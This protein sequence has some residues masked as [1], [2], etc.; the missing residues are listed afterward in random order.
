[1]KLAGSASGSPLRK[2]STRAMSAVFGQQVAERK[3]NKVIAALPH[4]QPTPDGNA[5]RRVYAPFG[6]SSYLHATP[7]LPVID[8]GL[9]DGFTNLTTVQQVDAKIADLNAAG[10]LPL[11]LPEAIQCSYAV[12]RRQT[13]LN[14]VAL[15]VPKPRNTIHILEPICEYVRARYTVTG[16][17]APITGMVIARRNHTLR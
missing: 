8:T 15:Y 10:D 3:I 2:W 13:Y 9:Y 4:L 5:I 11:L 12:D 6:Y 17:T 1:M 16:E 7:G 14:T